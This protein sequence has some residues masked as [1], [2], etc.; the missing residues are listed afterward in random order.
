VEEVLGKVRELQERRKKSEP[1]LSPNAGQLMFEIVSTFPEIAATLE[2]V[3]ADACVMQE[4][5]SKIQAAWFVEGKYP[6][7]HVGWQQTLRKEWPTLHEAIMAQNNALSRLST[8][9]Q[10]KE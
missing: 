9:Y 7:Y 6:K 5:A 8:T 10:P 1:F 4:A 3:Y 2:R